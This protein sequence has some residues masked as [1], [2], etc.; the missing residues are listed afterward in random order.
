L[1]AH[2]AYGDAIVR[3]RIAGRTVELPREGYVAGVLAGESSV[4]RSDEALKA[5]AVAARTYA[6][7]HPARHAAEGFDFCSTTHCQRVDL[8]AVTDR[9][10]KAAEATEGELLWK[11]GRPALTLYSLD[12][13]RDPGSLTWSWRAEP[14][15]VLEA[16]ARSRL[17]APE[18]LRAIEVVQRN[19]AGRA[20]TLA[21]IGNGTVRISAESFRLAVGRE[22]GWN[23]LRSDL[24]EVRELVFQGRGAGHGMG[25]CQRGA[26][27]MGV[28]G[29]GYREILAVAYPGTVLGVTARGISWQRLCGS[30]ACVMTTDPPSDRGVLATAERLATRLPWPVSGV[31]VRVYPDVDTFRDATGEPGWVAA[32]TAGKRIHM[33]PAAKLGRAL[34]RTLRHELLHVAIEANAGAELP[35]WFHEGLAL[36]LAGGVRGT[37]AIPDDAALRRTDDAA[38]ARRAYEQAGRAVAGLVARYGETAVLDWVKRGLPPEVRNASS[39]QAA[40]KSK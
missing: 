39:S 21:L 15:K 26:D 31:E 28:D 13:G 9:L 30:A 5:M 38:A 33:Q 29:R 3:V 36:Y 32:H 37:A 10:S 25:L 23:T 19:A 18:D 11:E 8:D 2:A 4:F 6:A 16:L 24:Y 1:I 34:E 12:C 20:L 7:H 17:R 35:V 40:T 14:A 27:Q 22:L